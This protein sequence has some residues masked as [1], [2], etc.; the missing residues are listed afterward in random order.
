MTAGEARRIQNAADKVG[1]SIHVV[2]SRAKGEAGPLS[3]WDYIIEGG[4]NSRTRDK[5]KNSLPTGH[6]IVK[7]E[8]NM[9]IFKTELNPDLPHVSFNP[10]SR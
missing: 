10:R 9:D 8:G 3:D 1:N 6:E 2:G 7:G 5:I 4:A